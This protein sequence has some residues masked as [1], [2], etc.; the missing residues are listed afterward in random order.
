MEAKAGSNS[1]GSFRGRLLNSDNYRGIRTMN[2]YVMEQMQRQVNTKPFTRMGWKA[3]GV[4]LRQP[5]CRNI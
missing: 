4:S 2:T 1:A 3:R 5:E